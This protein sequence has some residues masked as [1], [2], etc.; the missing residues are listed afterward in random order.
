MAVRLPIDLVP[1]RVGDLQVVA[2]MAGEVR[3]GDVA[4]IGEVGGD[5]SGADRLV[6]LAVEVTPVRLWTALRGSA[7]QRVGRGRL[8]AVRA[9][10]H[11][12]DARFRGAHVLEPARAAVAGLES[13]PLGKPVEPI[14]VQLD[15][16]GEAA[17]HVAPAI[18][19]PHPE[20]AGRARPD[21]GW[22]DRCQAVRPP[23]RHLDHR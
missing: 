8:Q 4:G 23:A 17:A 13:V 9:H 10:G 3:E 6:A 7:D 16:A 21:G 19:H 5:G 20:P 12:M 2:L 18:L 22:T 15:A 14:R 11:A 1:D